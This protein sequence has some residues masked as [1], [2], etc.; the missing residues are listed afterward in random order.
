[1][2]QRPVT[3][4]WMIMVPSVTGEVNRHFTHRFP[5]N[6]ALAL[7]VIEGLVA[8]NLSRYEVAMRERGERKPVLAHVSV[9][10]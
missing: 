5:C 7:L 3:T 9:K 4:G 10:C 1:M 8:L 2:I 6:C